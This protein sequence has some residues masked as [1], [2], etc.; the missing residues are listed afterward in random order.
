[1]DIKSYLSGNKLASNQSVIIG[2]D[3]S[4]RVA[5]TPEEA[6][7]LEVVISNSQ[8]DSQFNNLTVGFVDESS[9][10]QD[11]SGDI[12][13]II[14]ALEAGEDPAELGEEFA[15]AAGSQIG[16]SPSSI[17][18]VVRT[19]EQTSPNKTPPLHARHRGNTTEVC[20]IP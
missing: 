7:P 16:S 9:N 20:F 11:I 13:D 12:D 5:N 18:S 4:V 8:S 3:G 19:A 10:I 1:M 6:L 15:T 2:R 14:E 17:T